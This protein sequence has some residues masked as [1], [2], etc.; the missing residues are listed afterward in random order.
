MSIAERVARNSLFNIASGVISA[1]VTVFLP[2]ILVRMLG[3][4]QFSAWVFILQMG[5]YLG[6]LNLGIQTAISRYVA[7]E[8]G[9]AEVQIP[10]NEVLTTGVFLLSGLGLFGT[11]VVTAI[12]HYAPF[13]H[14]SL[15][16]AFRQDVLAGLPWIATCFALLLPLSGI[17]GFF[18]GKRKNHQILINNAALKVALFILLPS[19]AYFT[20]DIR[21]MVGAYV[22]AHAIAVIHYSALM[23]RGS[24]GAAI[25]W[26]SFTRR[27][28]LT[29]TRYCSGVTIWNF[30]M[31][32]V[33]GLSLIIVAHFDY[34]A[35]AAYS[36]LVG[37]ITLVI[38]IHTAIFGNLLPEYSAALT[39][40]SGTEKGE[41]LVVATRLGTIILLV[42]G[43]P[44]ALMPSEILKLWMATAYIPEARNVL[45][46]LILAM[47]IRMTASPYAMH[48]LA[49]GQQRMGMA[50]AFF[51]GTVTSVLSY[52]LATR[53]GAIGVAF[54]SLI[55]ACAGV[56][57][58]IL[59]N[60]P[61]DLYAVVPRVRFV[62]YGLLVPAAMSLPAWVLAA[63]EA[64]GAAVPVI[65][66]VAVLLIVFALLYF[67]GLTPEQRVF[68][69]SLGKSLLRKIRSKQMVREA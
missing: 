4:D 26:S 41:A 34:R 37:A 53:Y 31:L 27:T 42:L 55:G 17:N 21:Y 64:S 44:L 52:A 24:Q 5:A 33:S 61:R 67:R 6:Y 68:A 50:T 19:A 15:P 59:F 30:S 36:M 48:L 11:L 32:L 39:R 38:G 9:A 49:S 29:L 10:A 56:S 46:L 35:V 47:A 12:A 25:R 13:V 7:L 14:Q 3:R 51:E 62:V 1:G 65:E 22:I 2:P 16:E 28:A 43:L 40:S 45:C 66:K 54:G 23:M 8:D 18:A 58:N 20:A 69:A 60:L 63:W 57:A